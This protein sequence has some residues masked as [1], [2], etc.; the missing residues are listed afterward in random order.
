MQRQERRE[1]LG[2]QREGKSTDMSPN[3]M[4]SQVLLWGFCQPQSNSGEKLKGAF[5]IPTVLKKKKGEEGKKTQVRTCRCRRALVSTSTTSPQN[6]SPRGAPE[7]D[8]LG[9]GSR[10]MSLVARR[11]YRSQGGGRAPSLIQLVSAWGEEGTQRDMDTKERRPCEDRGRDGSDKA[12]RRGAADKH[13]APRTHPPPEPSRSN[14]PCRHLDFGLLA[15]RLWKGKL[16]LCCF[17]PPTVCKFAT[18]APGSW[19][20]LETPKSTPWKYM[21][22][23]KY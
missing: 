11:S 19:Y 23:H 8:Y 12:A 18:A 1:E 7:C 22:R 16:S 10:Q 21:G 13:R 20:K 15:S 2:S 3:Y 14:Q 5:R 6:S 9:E 17:E 4:E